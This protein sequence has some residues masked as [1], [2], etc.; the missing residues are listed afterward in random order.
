MSYL[1]D[2]HLLLTS[3]FMLVLTLSPD[4]FVY[5]HCLQDLLVDAIIDRIEA[6]DSCRLSRK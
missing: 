5:A 4:L 3:L 1:A 2:V 6:Q